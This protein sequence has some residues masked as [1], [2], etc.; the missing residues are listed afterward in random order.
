M[1]YTVVIGTI[2]HDE[3]EEMNTHTMRYWSKVMR[4]LGLWVVES[5]QDFVPDVKFSAS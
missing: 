1:I 4:E 5:L 3:T 2:L